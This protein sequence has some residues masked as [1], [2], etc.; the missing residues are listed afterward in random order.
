MPNYDIGLHHL[1]A[2]SRRAIKRH[3]VNYQEGQDRYQWAKNDGLLLQGG[4]HS[5][6]AAFL[7]KALGL[8]VNVTAPEDHDQEAASRTRP[9]KKSRH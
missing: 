9:R 2:L 6:L 8:I 1:V 4:R 5:R 7:R 3:Q